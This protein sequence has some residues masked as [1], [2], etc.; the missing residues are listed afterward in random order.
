[1]FQVL[2]YE[3]CLCTFLLFY[4]SSYRVVYFFL[5][6][7]ILLSNIQS[8]KSHYPEASNIL[9]IR[10]NGMCHSVYT[11]RQKV[12]D[13]RSRMESAGILISP[14]GWSARVTASAFQGD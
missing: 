13:C 9:A 12:N 4:R 11:R 5:F 10:E 2:M 3:M 14:G 1:M 6:D 7:I 8:F